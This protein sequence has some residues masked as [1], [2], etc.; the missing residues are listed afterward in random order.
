MMV[1]PTCILL[2]SVNIARLS[3]SFQDVSPQTF[4]QDFPA[5]IW[6]KIMLETATYTS[7]TDGLPFEE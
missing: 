7:E 2:P 1:Q 6:K 4:G 3:G 5:V